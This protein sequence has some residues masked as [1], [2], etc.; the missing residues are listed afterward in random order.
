M[1]AS[2]EHSN[3]LSGTVKYGAFLDYLK[4]YTL[5][6]TYSVPWDWI[7]IT[8]QINGGHERSTVHRPLIHLQVYRVL[9]TDTTLRSYC[10]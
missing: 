2:C 3:E 9:G 10:P 4:N 1:V 7:L 8:T 6:K 5:L